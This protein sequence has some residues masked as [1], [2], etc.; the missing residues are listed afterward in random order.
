[1][2]ICAN[3]QYIRMLRCR[4]VEDYIRNRASVRR[5]FRD[6]DRGSVSG[7]MLGQIRARIIPVVTGIAITV[8]GEDRYFSRHVDERQGIVTGASSFQAPIPCD[9][10]G[11]PEDRESVV[12]GKGV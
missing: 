3:D 9:G 1:M 4:L 10:G 11:I 8:D 7:E 5:Q 12:W 6:F 2:A